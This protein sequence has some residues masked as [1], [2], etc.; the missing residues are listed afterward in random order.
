MEL[1]LPLMPLMQK[2]EGRDS[3]ALCTPFSS[4]EDADRLPEDVGEEGRHD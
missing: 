4:T 1:E 2:A 3:G